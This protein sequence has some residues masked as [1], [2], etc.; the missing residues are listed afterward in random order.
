MMSRLISVQP[1]AQAMKALR[2]VYVTRSQPHSLLEL[3]E[4]Q[5]PAS[6]LDVDP[7][8]VHEG[9][10]PRFVTFGLLGLFKPRNRLVQLVLLHQ[11]DSDVVVRIAELRIDL[12]RAEALLRGLRQA[13]LE[14]HGPPQEGMGLRRRIHLDRALVELDR[15]IQLSVDLVAVGLLPEFRRSSQSRSF[16]HFSS[17]RLPDA[18]MIKAGHRSPLFAECGG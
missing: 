11:V 10:L 14:A 8:Q 1:S 7:P 9:K 18:S 2:R 6:L 5:P 3:A 16:F 17:S 15:S 12:D 13:A 4:R